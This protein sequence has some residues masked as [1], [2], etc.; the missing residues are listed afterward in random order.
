MYKVDKNTQKYS[1]DIDVLSESVKYPL[2]LILG[3]IGSVW[4]MKYLVNLRNAIK[5]ADIF[6]NSAK[7]LGVISIFTLPT[8]FINAYFAK[9]QKMGARISDMMTMQELEDYR[10]FADYSEFQ[11]S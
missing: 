4:G 8:L 10:F 5:P 11:N 7:Y 3:T 9:A 1:S 2:T 6:K